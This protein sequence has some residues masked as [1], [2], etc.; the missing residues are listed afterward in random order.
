MSMTDTTVLLDIA[1][2]F[3]WPVDDAEIEA[4]RLRWEELKKA[5]AGMDPG[6]KLDALSKSMRSGKRSRKVAF[7][8]E[9][10]HLVLAGWVSLVCVEGVPWWL[11]ENSGSGP[12]RWRW[13]SRAI[14]LCGRPAP[15][16][17]G[18]AG[19]YAYGWKGEITQ[20][21]LMTW[22]QQYGVDKRATCKSCLAAV[23]PEH[24]VISYG[25][26]L[27]HHLYECPI[28]C[29]QCLRDPCGPGL[30]KVDSA[31]DHLFVDGV[32]VKPGRGSDR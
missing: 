7:K 17:Q 32:Q 20:A 11:S 5:M 14:A 29:A 16:A 19:P 1:K 27:R 24:R 13:L 25:L 31:R 4:R 10:L 28:S 3:Y 15:R 8:A 30:A 18:A 23:G 22:D 12:P 6:E 9:P 26:E 2:T 21:D